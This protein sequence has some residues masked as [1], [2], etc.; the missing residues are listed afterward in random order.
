MK[1]L[2]IKRTENGLVAD[3][4]D[5]AK[6]MGVRH[7]HLLR[8][9]GKYATVLSQNPILD[10]GAITRVED[11]FVEKWTTPELGNKSTKYYE[12]TKKGCDMI[13]NKMIGEKGILFTAAYIN[14]FYAME[15]ELRDLKI[16][17]LETQNKQLET[18]TKQLESKAKELSRRLERYETS[19]SMPYR[20]V[21]TDVKNFLKAKVCASP[22]NLD[23]HELYDT[24]ARWRR[25][26]ELTPIIIFEQAMYDLGH[27]K[28]W[29]DD[30]LWFGL[31]FK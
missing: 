18:Q 7:S 9:I 29:E 25:F 2:T 1:E 5:V 6:M 3:S 16:K 14:R 22:G 21:V 30:S 17:Q 31:E 15:E 20:Y 24:Y 4:R 12:I 27:R 28:H 10:C 26:Q 11:F 23:C 8:D 19:S 13:A